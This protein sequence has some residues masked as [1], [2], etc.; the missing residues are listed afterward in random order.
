MLA[1]ALCLLPFAAGAATIVDTIKLLT[2]DP[3]GGIGDRGGNDISIAP[4]GTKVVFHSSSTNLISGVTTDGNGNIY[5]YDVV[6]G[7]NSLITKGLSGTGGNGWSASPRFSPDG[8]KVLFESGATDLISGMTTGNSFNVYL[9]DVASDVITLITKSSSNVGADSW[10]G[11][12]WFSPDGTKVVFGSTATDLIDGVATTPLEH[13][14]LYDIASGATTLVT[15]GSSGIGANGWSSANRDSSVA[16]TKL[17]FESSATDL[18]DGVTTDSRTNIYLYDIVTGV[19]TLVT[20]GPSDVGGNSGS[21]NPRVSPDGT[22]VAF[23]SS[24]TNLIEGMTTSGNDNI[25]LYDIASGV[26]VLVTNSS[27]GLGGNDDSYYPWISPD[28]SKIAFSSYATNLISEMTTTS[29]GNIYLYD[30]A[31]G[32]ITLVTRGPSDNGVNGGAY[33]G[34]SYP[35]VADNSALIFSSIATDVVSG[36]TSDWCENMYRYDIATGSIE[37]LTKGPRGTGINNGNTHNYSIS[38][39]GSKIAFFGCARDFVSGITTTGG[40]HVYLWTRIVYVDVIFEALDGSVPV[41][42][43]VE[44][45]FAVE[46]LAQPERPGFVFNGWYTVERELWSFGDPV[47][48]NMTLLASWLEL[49]TVTFDAQNGTTSLVI[50]DIVE[51]SLLTK[52]TDPTRIG[53]TFTGWWTEPDGGVLWDFAADTVSTNLTLYGRWTPDEGPTPPP[54]ETPLEQPV[55][56]LSPISPATPATGDSATIGAMVL[57]GLLGS[58]VVGSLCRKKR[59]E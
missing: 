34:Y 16:G 50:E 38:T 46:E 36:L 1:S 59:F 52:P 13:I 28:G 55:S 32:T 24:A 37:L 41:T 5:L 43:R 49:L 30:I 12:A 8:A 10:A 22:K 21:Y 14:F 44:Q 47:N 42:K 15:K 20:K 23:Q 53:Y 9:Y 35:F 31:S 3:A 45:G 57:A 39:D 2:F 54:Q 18:V 4:D 25:Y 29:G 56:P 7:T 6:S 19:T 33:F 27:S 48:S 17:V 51:G 26:T 58:I 40:E 11:A